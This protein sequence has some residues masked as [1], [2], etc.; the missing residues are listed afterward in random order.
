MAQASAT[1]HLTQGIAVCL[2]RYIAQ[3]DRAQ[4][5]GELASEM[6][7][8]QTSFR[9]LFDAIVPTAADDRETFSAMVGQRMRA[10]RAH[11]ELLRT[12]ADAANPRRARL[13]AAQISG[14]IATCEGLLLQ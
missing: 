1:Q 14:Q 10:K 2:G 9:E 13:A 3:I 6:R 7:E 11:S 8:R 5:H 12:A 4:M